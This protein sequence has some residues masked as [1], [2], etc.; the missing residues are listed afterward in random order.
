[1]M[2]ILVAFTLISWST[3]TGMEGRVKFNVVRRHLKSGLQ[4][5]KD[6]RYTAYISK[7]RSCYIMVKGTI[8]KLRHHLGR[9]EHW[10]LSNSKLRGLGSQL[11]KCGTMIMETYT[12]RP[13]CDGCLSSGTCSVGRRRCGE[14]VS[15]GAPVNPAGGGS[16]S[17]RWLS[18]IKDRG[19]KS[20]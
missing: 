5:A 16:D 19:R 20:S 13:Q 18:S 15:S 2:L 11:G 3:C 9:F 7:N 10:K 6:L 12:K 14:C 1:M 17:K 8:S 4:G